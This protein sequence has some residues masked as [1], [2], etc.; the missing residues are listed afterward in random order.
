WLRGGRQDEDGRAARCLV[1]LLRRERLAVRLEYDRGLFGFEA[2]LGLGRMAGAWIDD[3]LRKGLTIVNAVARGHVRAVAGSARERE[4]CTE[5]KGHR[6]HGILLC[7][8]AAMGAVSNEDS[9]GEAVSALPARHARV[10]FASA[11][12]RPGASAFARL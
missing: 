3:L 4:R 11:A 10:A 12:F 1:H 7:V 8:S 2:P 5:E 9:S 6:F